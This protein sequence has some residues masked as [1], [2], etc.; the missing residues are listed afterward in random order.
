MT[1]TEHSSC[2]HQGI[3]VDRREFCFS[4]KYQSFIWNARSRPGGVYLEV[5]RK[6]LF[7]VWAS[8]LLCMRSICAFPDKRAS[9]TTPQNSRNGQE[10]QRIF[11][12]GQF[13]VKYIK[14][15][16]FSKKEKNKKCYE[17]WSDIRR[18]QWSL[19]E[20]QSKQYL[21]CDKFQSTVYFL[22][23]LDGLQLLRLSYYFLCKLRLYCVL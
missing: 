20:L 12:N 6:Q 3:K 14:R 16:V 19:T 11:R 4:I 23:K 22:P 9:L 13:S 10:L 8:P 15:V 2:H 21:Q 1:E 18:D 5:E 17:W 7:E